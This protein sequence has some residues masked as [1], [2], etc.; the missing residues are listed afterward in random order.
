VVSTTVVAPFL[1]LA[2]VGLAPLL[3]LLR[4][5]HDWP[6]VTNSPPSSTQVAVDEAPVP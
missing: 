4:G 6:S 3:A 2:V 5:T 1:T